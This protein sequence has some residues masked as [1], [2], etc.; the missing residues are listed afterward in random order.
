MAGQYTVT[1]V[2]ERK[3][4]AHGNKVFYVDTDSVEDVY[5][6]T[7]GDAPVV[8]QT[9]EWELSTSDKGA[10]FRNPQKEGYENKSSGGSSR[11]RGGGYKDDPTKDRKITRLAVQ[12]TAALVI[13]PTEDWSG[14]VNLCNILCEDAFEYAGESPAAAPQMS[15]DDLKKELQA[16]FKENNIPMETGV[17][18]IAATCGGRTKLEVGDDL[19][20]ILAKAKEL[21]SDDV[22]F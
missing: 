4:D 13:N 2:R 11:G 1:A 5:Y 19:E 21:E 17:A 7:K 15:L 20:T 9:Y 6:A 18:A 12:K 16:M 8:G 10:R 22:P 3:P 14:F